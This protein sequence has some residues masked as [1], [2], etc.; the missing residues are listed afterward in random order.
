M[1]ENNIQDDPM[2][3]YKQRYPQAAG[4]SCPRDIFLLEAVKEDAVE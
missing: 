2:I 3:S 4:N 1:K